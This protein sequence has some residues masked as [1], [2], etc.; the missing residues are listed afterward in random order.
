M[1][2]IILWSGCH[3]GAAK[4][5][6]HFEEVTVE[7]AGTEGTGAVNVRVLWSLPGGC[8]LDVTALTVDLDGTP[9]AFDRAWP[10]TADAE[11]PDAGDWRLFSQTFPRGPGDRV[12][13]FRLGEEVY[14]M[15]VPDPTGARHLAPV[16]KGSW[17][18]RPGQILSF[19]NPRAGFHLADRASASLGPA[20][21][22]VGTKSGVPATATV[23]DEQVRVEVPA[24]A[25]GS[26]ML[27]VRSV[28]T[29]DVT[30]CFADTCRARLTAKVVHPLT[31]T[32]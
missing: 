30:P 10:R 25:A 27:S 21:G 23:A 26:Y 9:V 29:L 12:F 14:T 16:T 4:T 31:V 1:L 32:E 28:G 13:T 2:S 6:V 18:A 8:G 3:L 7:L 19:A 17:T 15:T 24:L 22:S 11:C 5:A 20:G